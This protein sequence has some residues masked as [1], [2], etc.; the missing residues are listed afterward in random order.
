MSDFDSLVGERKNVTALFADVVGSTTRVGKLDA[1][2]AS[3]FLGAIVSVLER[4]VS[5]HGGITIH[6]LGDG[7]ISV[8]GAPHSVEDHGIR[9]CNA[10]LAMQKTIAKFSQDHSRFPEPVQIRVGINSGE[11]V[12]RPDPLDIFGIMVHV[13]SRLQ[14][15]AS[16]GAIWISRSTFSNVEDGFVCSSLGLKVFKNIEVPVDVYVLERAKKIDRPRFGLEHWNIDVPF[17]GRGL[18]KQIL[19]DAFGRLASGRGSIIALT[20]DGGIGKSRLLAEARTLSGRSL[21]WLEGFSTSL[22]RE[23]AYLPI[24]QILRRY[25][26]ANDEED[27]ALT[28][29]KLDT[30]LQ[31][32]FGKET[33][34]V[35][36]YVAI[37]LGLRIS[38]AYRNRVAYL[39]GDAMGRQLRRVLRLLF[40]QI[41][42]RKPTVLVFE[43]F[44]WTDEAT[45]SA[46]EHLFPL[47]ETASLTICFVGRGEPDSLDTKLKHV[48]RES[49]ASCFVEV[50]LAPLRPNESME[51]FD[52]LF[53]RQP[54]L[55][56]LRQVITRNAEG[57]PLFME[58]VIR[59]LL[60]TKAL[61]RHDD[62]W[63]LTANADV[64]QI[65]TTIQDLISARVDRLPQEVKQ[66]LTAASVIG[67]A[68]L[69]K[70]L[71][72]ISDSTFKLDDDLTNLLKLGF[73]GE[74]SRDPEL[75][76]IFRHAVIQ[77]VTYERLLRS[78]RKQIHEKVAETLEK[79]F[80]D[81]VEE[82]CGV[83]AYHFGRAE[84][85]D[86][87][88]E[89]LFRA[90]AKC[91]RLAA[92]TEALY[93]YQQAVTACVNAFGEKMDT[94]L[95]AL[96]ERKLGE[97]Y[98]RRGEHEKAFYHLDRALSFLG[99][100]EIPRTGPIARQ[101]L[102]EI[103]VQVFRSIGPSR[104]RYKSEATFADRLAIYQM[105]GWMFLFEDPSRL[106]LSVLVILNQAEK[107]RDADGAAISASAL[108]YCC[109]LLGLT[110]LGSAYLRKSEATAKCSEN[111]VSHCMVVLAAAWHAAYM[112]E[113]ASAIVSFEKAAGMSWQ[114]GDLRAYGSATFG[115][116]L[117]AV[118]R[119]DFAKAWPIAQ[120]QFKLGQEAADQVAIRTG[121]FLKGMILERAGRWHESE[122]ILR[123]CL[124]ATENVKDYLFIPLASAELGRCLVRQGQ[125]AEA[126]VIFAQAQRAVRE[127]GLR[128]HT[129]AML[130]N[131]IA[132]Y[133]L[134]LASRL[135]ESEREHEL[136][137]AKSVCLSAVRATR[138]FPTTHP[139]ALRYSGECEWLLGQK[140]KAVST[141]KAAAAKAVSL[142]SVY[143]QAM[144]ELAMG[145]LTNNESATGRGQA[146]MATILKNVF[147]ERCEI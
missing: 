70:V 42:R 35:L 64:V 85:W 111:P 51:F 59:T 104:I 141:W 125:F 1:E 18:E 90:A 71:Q 147:V 122:V 113:P 100:P 102:R 86:K 47:T 33:E 27:S 107:F 88:Q 34:D 97:A 38:D 49:H 75:R 120:R 63:E 130:L 123:E 99:V 72:A 22:G 78:R 55:G 138:R 50:A 136:A 124:A 9:A 61:V 81:H 121:L 58:E 16:P 134:I 4:I 73:I 119:G 57:N 53:H 10:A 92:D 30:S 131:A 103:S 139:E 21:L 54:Q 68:F 116:A 133:R 110:K 36:P 145:R 146:M 24:I 13:A 39:D 14:T 135:S 91:D 23:V 60:E 2:D 11:A 143:D 142:G 17:V 93:H 89:Y 20:G 32:L 82:L 31:E 112:G 69:Y 62:A 79:S 43:D 98:Y 128:G 106:L 46:I 3:S 77:E 26:G 129:V 127:R 66:V 19:V 44:Y 28:W 65:P 5:D 94:T 37:L 108:V 114:C 8:F 126:D 52:A 40:E 84:R 101:L 29:S 76:Y 41:A 15:N 137:K 117:I 96:V 132:E 87:A 109:D 6:R 140:Q 7:I 25:I 12:V 115:A 74:Q 118:Q 56:R 95:R 83:L 45:V 144:I 67:K 80:P 105:M 48:A